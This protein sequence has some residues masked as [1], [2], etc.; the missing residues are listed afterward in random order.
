MT[1][2]AKT[3]VANCEGIRNA[4]LDLAKNLTKNPDDPDLNMDIFHRDLQTA[5][6]S[7]SE[8]VWKKTLW[9]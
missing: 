6:H 5:I 4:V 2:L 7:D 1:V 9:R 3:Y 8:K